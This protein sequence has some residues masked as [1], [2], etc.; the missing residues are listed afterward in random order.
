MRA[1]D[2]D[3]LEPAQLSGRLEASAFL[4][5]AMAIALIVFGV[6]AAQLHAKQPRLLLI[7]GDAEDAGSR[8]RS[9]RS[10]QRAQGR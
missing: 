8:L 3:G 9:R 7:G 2:V 1:L 10:L 6:S 4:M 5:G